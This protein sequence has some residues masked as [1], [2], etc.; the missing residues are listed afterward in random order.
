MAEFCQVGKDPTT[1]SY[2]MDPNKV[3]LMVYPVE[4]TT[5]TIQPIHRAKQ[6]DHHSTT[7]HSFHTTSTAEVLQFTT[8]PR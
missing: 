6:L 8:T 3:W 1:K 5:N 7:T 2:R 4:I